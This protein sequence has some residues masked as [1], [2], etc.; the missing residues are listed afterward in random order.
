MSRRLLLI[1]FIALVLPATRAHA[2]STACQTVLS[3]PPV[4]SHYVQKTLERA[5]AGIAYAQAADASN[6]FIYFV[7][8][9]QQIASSWISINNIQLRITDA[10]R[11]LLDASACRRFDT[12]VL[13]C[14]MDAVRD[15]MK[16][17][18]DRGSFVGIMRL[19]A[20]LTFLDER[21]DHL[22]RG[23]L[24][25]AYID[26][27]WGRHQLFDPPAPVWCCPGIP[28]G[29]DEYRCVETPP[30]IC[31]QELEGAWTNTLDLC[32]GN[33]CDLPAGVAA[34]PPEQGN[35]CPYH[36][37][38]LDAMASGFGCDE[39]I[40]LPRAG[41][42][43]LAV[44][45]LALQTVTTQINDFRGQAQELL[46]LQAELEG[47]LDMD[48]SVPPL[49]APREHKTAYGCLVRNGRCSGRPDLSC[50]TD[51]DCL[52]GDGGTCVL[53]QGACSGNLAIHCDDDQQCADRDA[54]TCKPGPREQLPLYAKRGAF[55]VDENHVGILSRFTDL[56]KEQG[57]QREYADDLKTAAEFPPEKEAESKQRQADNPL[58]QIVRASARF[59]FALWSKLQGQSESEI[60]PIAAD[61]QMTIAD[62]M[63]PLR[64]AV[65]GLTRHASK[66]EGMRSFVTG[67]S[68]W[69]RL[70]CIDRACNK[71][72]EQI[73]KIAFT[74]ECFPYA[75]G[76]F[77]NDKPEE[78]RWRK[79]AQAAGL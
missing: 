75:N 70:T 46:Q 31:E 15:E 44:E 32:L 11:G 26:P 69:L 66:K 14:K 47:L 65:R 13:E 53:P 48:T 76:E 37:D 12:L 7:P 20:L 21:F 63:G 23:G 4:S 50:S 67:L 39:D 42:L 57:Q 58:A 18:L 6:P 22:T 38:Y 64:N 40:M 79:C 29:A 19:Q 52:A 59:T 77:L 73:L 68:Y 3:L 74:D 41:H 30:T 71:R 28:D 78:P 61:A 60:Y 17:A 35:M 10:Q 54:G 72:L 16:A 56:R 49:P 2:L 9:A 33:G 55:S 43:P 24:D 27:T 34:V 51:G 8:W 5:D 45:L 1:G 62:E 36:S 25:P